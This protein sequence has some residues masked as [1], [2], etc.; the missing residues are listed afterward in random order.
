[1]FDD[2]VFCCL[3]CLGKVVRELKAQG[4]DRSQV[5]LEVKKLLAL[6]EQYKVVAGHEWA[7][8]A[9]GGGGTKKK[10]KGKVEKTPA[11]PKGETMLFSLGIVT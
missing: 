4:G 9:A 8:S 1:M 5:D 10:E 7:S 11:E 3:C 6:K 2:M